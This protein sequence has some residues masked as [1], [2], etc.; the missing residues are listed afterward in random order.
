MQFL[1]KLKQPKILTLCAP[2]LQPSPSSP[3]ADPPH[4]QSPDRRLLSSFVGADAR[5]TISSPSSLGLSSSSAHYFSLFLFF[6]LFFVFF[7]FSSVS[8]SY[9]HEWWCCCRCC[10]SFFGFFCFLSSLMIMREC[11]PNFMVDEHLSFWEC[12]LTLW[13]L[14]L[15][16]M[17]VVFKL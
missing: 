7:F 2:P 6:S 13:W 16:V 14:D 11:V 5:H 9:S 3:T 17:G 4:L 8:S 10:L 15:I 1:I 12:V